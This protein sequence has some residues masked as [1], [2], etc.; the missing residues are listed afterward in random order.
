M[1]G[2]AVCGIA[3]QVYMLWVLI[4]IYELCYVLMIRDQI[5][6]LHLP[7]YILNIFLQRRTSAMILSITFQSSCKLAGI[8]GK[9]PHAS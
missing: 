4:A 9:G 2:K 5:Q 8:L 7:L 1:S 6:D 3:Y